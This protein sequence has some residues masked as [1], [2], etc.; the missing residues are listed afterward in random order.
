MK[1]LAYLQEV[2]EDAVEDAINAGCRRI[3]DYLGVTDGG[4]AGVYF[5]GLEHRKKL[6][7]V[8]IAYA[9]EEINFNRED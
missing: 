7:E 3:Q 2:V 5:S 4:F 8:F 6:L 9:A 1:A